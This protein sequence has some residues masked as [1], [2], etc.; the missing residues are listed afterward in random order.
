MTESNPYAAPAAVVDD[1]RVHSTWD[2]DGRKASR[3]KR[4]GAALLDLLINLMWMTPIFWGATMV[5]GVRQGLKPAAP[6]AGL[7]LLGFVL[8]VAMI[9]VNC[10]LIHRY[11]QTIGKRTLDI[12]IVR[13]DGERVSLARYIFLRVMPISLL[14]G[15]PM[16]G[17]VAA[18]VDVLIIFGPER[19]C[20]HDLIADTIVVDV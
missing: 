8:L 9:V 7:M 3:G 10:V 20:L 4:L 17:K 13:S 19:R 6:M 1:V 5:A 12:A 2:M 14:G 11:G 16:V 18:L 15:V